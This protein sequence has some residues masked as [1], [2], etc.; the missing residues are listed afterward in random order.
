MTDGSKFFSG[1]E[2]ARC[3]IREIT[4]DDIDALFNLYAQPGVTDFIEP[5]YSR[6]EEIEYRRLYVD[7][8]YRVYGFGLWGVF[9][10]T[11]GEL[12]GQNGIE[13]R[14]GFTWDTADLGYVIHPLY[15]GLGLCKET[16]EA[17]LKYAT[18][19]T[20]LDYVQARIRDD[21]TTSIHVCKGFG[22]IPTSRMSGDERVYIKPL[23]GGEVADR[24]DG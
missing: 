23:H 9:L 2:T 21:N 22:F 16:T 14:E 5:L 8:I 6:E 11:T 19:A 24:I 18:D 13:Y 10:K 4:E 1:I 3:L 15:R 7:N 17:V 12:I 20:A